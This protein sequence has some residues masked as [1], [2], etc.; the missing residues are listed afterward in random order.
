[1]PK[2]G[3]GPRVPPELLDVLL[4]P[5]QGRDLVHQPVVGHPRVLVGGRVG[6]QEPFNTKYFFIH[7]KVKH[8]WCNAVSI[9]RQVQSRVSIIIYLG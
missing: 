9:I 3:D 2:D 5:L 1:M 8:S 6:V 4:D 7:C